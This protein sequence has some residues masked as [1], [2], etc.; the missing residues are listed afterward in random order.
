MKLVKFGELFH[1]LPKSKIK[2]GEGLEVG[3]YP[4]FTSSKKLTK[5]LDVYTY[6][7]EA[8]IFG[9]G[10]QASV[11]YYRGKFAT[12][13]DCFVVNA[14]ID[15]LNLKYVYLYLKSH[16]KILEEGFKG[17]GLKHISKKYISNIKIPLPE[18]FDDQI[19]IANLLTQAEE[20]ISKRE[21]SIKL[22]DELLKSTF[23]DM[24]LSNIEEKSLKSLGKYIKYMTS[25]ARGWAKY[26]SEHGALFL[27]INNVKDA[28]LVLN[29]ITRV[30]PPDGVE[31][32]RT[33]VKEGDLL[34][35]IT[36]DLGRTAVIPKS[37][38]KA[39]INQHLALLRLDTDKLNPVYAAHFYF[40][41]YGQHLLKK[42]NKGGVKAG[43]NFS[44]IK[45]MKIFIPP[46]PLQDKFSAIVQQ[47]EATKAYYQKSL[48]ELNNL[49]GSLS[50]RAFRGELD[51]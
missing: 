39:Y 22:L 38:E 31:G 3:K 4:L 40:S 48:D 41:N 6:D 51:Y 44:D 43:L 26:Y 24:F 7:L 9:T 28:K 34:F 35:S 1:F 23:L 8:L 11:H 27:R 49:F 13:T 29:D 42:F 19:K 46:K 37:F 14:K 15:D 33:E 20:L 45:K 17:A 16:I 25:G 30:N 5:F 2:A 12:S 36:A 21:E 10:G 47:V 18:T 32:S 50:Q